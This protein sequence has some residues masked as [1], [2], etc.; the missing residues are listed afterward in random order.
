VRSVLRL[1]FNPFKP[2][3]GQEFSPYL[4][5]Y[6]DVLR[7]KDQLINDWLRKEFRFTLQIIRKSLIQNAVLL[8]VKVDGIYSYHWRLK[9]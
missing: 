5:K 2:N 1:S 6:T 7:Y 9:G 8:I 3:N 4:S